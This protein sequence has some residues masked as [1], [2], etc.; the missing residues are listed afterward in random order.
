MIALRSALLLWA[1]L[2]ACGGEIVEPEVRVDLGG[3]EVVGEG[4]ERVEVLDPSGAP[5]VTQAAP[6]PLRELGVRVPWDEGGTHTVRVWDGQ[7]L[8]ERPVEIPAERPRFTVEVQAP[9]GQQ[10]VAVEDGAVISVP[11]IGERSAQVGV[12]ARA[13]EDVELDT[14]F[15]DEDLE[16]HELRS[17]ERA[18]LI[19][20]LEAHG[21]SA[22]VVVGDMT[23]TLEPSRTSVED[24]AASL[25]IEEIVFPA[26]V[27]GSADPARV[28][29]RVALPSHWWRSVL[30][31]TG[32]GF[33]PRDEF[34][35]YA[36]QAV[37]LRNDA[38][39][40][41]NVVLEARI[42]DEQG[43]YAPA[44]RPRMRAGDDGSGRVRALLRVPAGESA[45]ATLPL[46]VDEGLLGID[47]VQSRSWTA[48][49]SVIPLGASEPIDVH[50]RPIHASR[51]SSTASLGLIAA[52]VAALLGTGGLI[53]RGRR[54][55]EEFQTSELMTIALFGAM[56][57][58]VGAAGR[59]LS[60]GVATLMG[61]FSPFL[62]GLVDDAFRYTLIAT[63]LV[64]LPRTGVATLAV[65]VS[66]LLSGLMLGTFQVTDVLF[67]GGRIFWLEAFLWLAGVT[68]STAWLDEA[69][70]KRWLRLSIG[71]GLASAATSAT[72]IV[73]MVTLY[74]LFF[75]DW[76]IVGLIAGPGFLYVV[77]AC[78]IAVPFADSLRRIQR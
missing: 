36:W 66:W 14:R 76:F 70:W 65:L 24:A 52:L 34:A 30:R 10:Q 49:I 8:H 41:I 11:V 5:I 78:L 2:L 47:E 60:T 75:A 77:L 40:P 69:P 73:L 68:R 42:V 23:F 61:P 44:F 19:R 51:G 72:G 31:A 25:Q 1:L 18:V 46:Y 12:F 38:T 74:R 53:T 43:Q 21:E 45:V 9:L 7:G 32:L 28:R 3:V 39:D 63:L 22:V 15:G 13:W 35:V 6:A 58:L 16:R 37:H 48:E 33:R 20:A 54:W 67:V 57:F 17:G 26:E 50:R 64:L 55:L 56:S 27:N 29:D 71:L 62:T 4:I 59:L